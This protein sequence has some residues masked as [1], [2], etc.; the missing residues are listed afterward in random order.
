MLK[1]QS[2]EPNKNVWLVD[3]VMKVGT[4]KDNEISISGDGIAAL[5]AKLY[6]VD[7]AVQI[8]PIMG[9]ESFVNEQLVNFKS[10]VALGDIIRF[11]THEYAIIDPSKNPVNPFG[12]P[13]QEEVGGGDATMF[14]PAGGAEQ[15]AASGWFIQGMQK[16]LKN[17]RYPID[18]TMILGRSKECELS[19]AYDRLSRKHAEFKLFDGVLFIKDLGSSN[20]ISHNGEKVEQAKLL[21]GD[22]VAFDKL[23]FTVIGPAGGDSQESTEDANLNETV[24]GAAITPEMI[25]QHKSSKASPSAAD[26][27]LANLSSDSSGEGSAVL[28]VVGIVV[29]VVI[30]AGAYFML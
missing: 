15:A 1:L 3:P 17:K 4:A 19:F 12:Q 2:K 26:A 24:M 22:T 18:K 23:E 20:G 14:R 5:H 6:I 28:I 25:K 21:P 9:A 7:G 10:P 30:V 13:K 11:G 16:S 27:E 29:A 8:E